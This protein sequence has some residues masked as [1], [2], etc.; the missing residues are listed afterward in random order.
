MMRVTTVDM[1]G[2]APGR[3]SALDVLVRTDASAEDA[4]RAAAAFARR[5]DACETVLVDECSRTR[6]TFASRT[7]NAAGETPFATHSLAGVAA[8]LVGTGRLAPGEVGWTA[9]AGTQWLWTDG[10]EVRVPFEGPAVRQEPAHDAAEF[11]WAT[12]ES[13]AGGVGRAFNFVRVSADPRGL[14]VPDLDRMRELE[15]TDLTAFRW[16]PA[17]REVLACVFAPG[18]GIP[19]DAGCLPAAA[20]LG[21]AALQLDAPDSTPLTIRQVTRHGTESVFGC[22]GSLRDGTARVRITGQ[23]WVPQGDDEKACEA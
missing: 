12:G 15:V 18:F 9:A 14:P 10:S 23:V 22:V 17:R 20:A 1:F 13:H 6:K 7:F 11:G 19:E 2:A 16:D 5:S 8:C 3:G 4:A 21:V